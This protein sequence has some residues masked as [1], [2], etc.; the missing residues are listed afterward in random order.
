MNRPENRMELHARRTEGRRMIQSML[1]GDISEN[2][3]RL[4]TLLAADPV[5]ARELDEYRILR[6]QLAALPRGRDQS[7]EILSR[8]P[9]FANATGRPESGRVYRFLR[10]AGLGLAASVALGASLFLV[11]SNALRSGSRETA[12]D[13]FGDARQNIRQTTGFSLADRVRGRFLPGAD[14]NLIPDIE[15]ITGDDADLRRAAKDMAGEK[16]VCIERSGL[17]IVNPGPQLAHTTPASREAAAVIW[18]S[19]PNAEY[20][21]GRGRASDTPRFIMTGWYDGSG[22]AVPLTGVASGKQRK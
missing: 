4:R 19:T 17:S 13:L 10:S 3:P 1:D 18:T 11:S 5:L 9:A 6:S 14:P 12:A 8:L 7:A 2:S 22:N 21:G 16:E 15:S 20:S